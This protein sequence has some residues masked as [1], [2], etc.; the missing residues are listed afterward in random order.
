MVDT[1]PESLRELGTRS[2]D[3]KTRSEGLTER[4][5]PFVLPASDAAV[6]LTLLELLRLIEGF[7]SHSGDMIA[8]GQQCVTV[9]CKAQFCSRRQ[10]TTLY[11]SKE[12]TGTD[13]QDQE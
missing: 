12:V 11:S 5:D 1:D 13:E 6:V 8:M 3:E 10:T 9:S 7:L 2:V 4:R